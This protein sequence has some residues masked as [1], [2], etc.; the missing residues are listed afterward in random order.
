MRFPRLE[1]YLD[2]STHLKVVHHLL[3]NRH[4]LDVPV[5]LPELTKGGFA[6]ASRRLGEVVFQALLRW[7]PR[8]FAALN[9]PVTAADEPMTDR[10][11]VE[12]LV[13]ESL[14][15]NTRVHIPTIEL[16]LNNASTG[17][18]ACEAFRLGEWLQLKPVIEHFSHPGKRPG[19]QA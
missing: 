8:E 5:S 16:I 17:K 19:A 10:D 11:I 2:N 14:T 15:R 12:M 4:A 9:A 13:C 18:E 7:H 1:I 3:P 6:D